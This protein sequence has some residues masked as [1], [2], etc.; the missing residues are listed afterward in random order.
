M[1]ASCQIFRNPDRMRRA[2]HGAGHWQDGRSSEESQR[3][4]C[5][6]LAQSDPG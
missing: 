4:Y 1:M 6:S 3:D 2:T 5:Q